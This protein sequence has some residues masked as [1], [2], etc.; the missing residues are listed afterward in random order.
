MN[1]YLKIVAGGVIGLLAGLFLA[2]SE[3][4]P[5]AS[6]DSHDTNSIVVSQYIAQ[7]DGQPLVCPDQSLP[8]D[9]TAWDLLQHCSEIGDGY[10]LE[11]Q[12]FDGLGVF[13]SQIGDLGP[14]S[15]TNYWQYWV[16]A[17]H[18]EVGSDSLTLNN[19]DTIVWEFLPSLE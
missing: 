2:N 16:N 7:P 3:L 13:V 1:T 11:H 9:S 10:T 14:N 4:L 19:N 5:Q 12:E 6:D 8:S 15:D 18:A 17:R